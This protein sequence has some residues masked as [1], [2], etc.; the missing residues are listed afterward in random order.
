M[1]SQLTNRVLLV[2][3]ASFSFN[4]ETAAS[5]AFQHQPGMEKMTI[6]SRV[7]DE[8]DHFAGTLRQNGV[9]VTVVEDTPFPPKPDAIFPNNW[10]SF[11][12]DGTIVL[13][14][15]QAANRRTERLIEIIDHV[16]GTEERTCLD[17]SMFEE[18]GIYL[19]GT[20]SIVF[21]HANK[22]AYACYSPRTNSGLFEEV[23]R[24]LGYQPVGFHASDAKG[25]AI[26]HTNVMMGIGEGFAIVCLE[27]IS[28]EAE[29]AFVCGSL[30]KGKLEIIPVTLKQVSDFAG[31]VLAL[32][33]MSGEQLLVLSRRAFNTLTTEQHHRVEQYARFVPMD[34][35]TIETIGGGSAR[36]MI[37]EVFLPPGIK[38]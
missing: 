23:A 21:D 2:R 19:E 27:S 12:C 16:A 25:Q 15:M 4:T 28:D 22:V 8:F 13:Y 7:Q 30:E 35:P 37:A 17:F 1:R 18:Q 5:N 14:P 38:P 36:C 3:P 6:L 9:H 29:R 11:H 33:S 26:Y 24:K 31:N 34:I 32:R 10:I 20:G